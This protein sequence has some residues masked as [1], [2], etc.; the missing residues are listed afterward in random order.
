MADH[1]GPGILDGE[2]TSMDASGSQQVTPAAGHGT[3]GVFEHHRGRPVS[4]VS[5]SIIFVGFLLGGIAF[6][7]GPAWW[8]LWVGVAV[9]AVGGILGLATGIFNDWY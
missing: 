6:V 3:P 1:V 2:L 7:V 5:V 4:W 8:L 9:T